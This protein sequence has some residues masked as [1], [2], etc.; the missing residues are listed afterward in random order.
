MRTK[1]KRGE[2]RFSRGWVK[3]CRKSY[4]VAGSR[5]SCCTSCGFGTPL[6]AFR[7][8]PVERG[9]IDLK[10]KK[11]IIPIVN[12]DFPYTI[13]F[14]PW[15]RLSQ[16]L[17]FIQKACLVHFCL[18]YILRKIVGFMDFYDLNFFFVCV[19]HEKMFYVVMNKYLN[20]FIYIC[21]L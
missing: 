3:A 8:K 7:E 5:R 9:K 12:F 18:Y 16:Y 11:K 2:I 10:K 19:C 4:Q 13:T 1:M 15:P 21:K 6:R 17:L 14:E 20:K